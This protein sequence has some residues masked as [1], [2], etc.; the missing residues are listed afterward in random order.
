MN[1]SFSIIGTGNMAYFLAHKLSQSRMTLKGVWGRNVFHSEVLAQ[2][3]GSKTYNSLSEIEDKEHHF[4]FIAVSDTAIA[5]IANQLHFEQ[6]TLIHTSG[7]SS[8]NEIILASKKCAVFWPIYSIAKE[9]LIDTTNIPIAIEASSVEIEQ[10]VMELALGVSNKAFKTNENERMRLHLAAVFANNFT[11][12]LVAL[13]QEICKNEGIPFEHLQPIITQTCERLKSNAAKTVQSGPAKRDDKMTMQ[14]HL[15]L[16]KST[17]D[18]A[19]LYQSLSASIRK[20][21]KGNEE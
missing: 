10:S 1:K 17:P 13:S 3:F 7:A 18:I 5:T 4:C 19:L 9:T 8:I 21:Y 12:H 11:N 6:T 15:E 2:Q 16:L 20:M 14:K